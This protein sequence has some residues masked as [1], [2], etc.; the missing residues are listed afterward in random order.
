MKLK[1]APPCRLTVNATSPFIVRAYNRND[2]LVVDLIVNLLLLLRRQVIAVAARVHSL[3]ALLKTVCEVARFVRLHG[4]NDRV[5]SITQILLPGAARLRDAVLLVYAAIVLLSAALVV[6]H[7]G[8]AE[9]N[10]L[11]RSL[12]LLLVLLRALLHLH[13]LRACLV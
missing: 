11:E 13:L 7:F 5:V 1:S 10:V 6:Q 9:V 12:L 4:L 3:V 8:V 2:Y